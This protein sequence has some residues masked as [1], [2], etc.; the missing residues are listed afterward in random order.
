[1]WHGMQNRATPA[2]GRQNFSSQCFKNTRAT[3]FD[4]H[5]K[6]VPRDTVTAGGTFHDFLQ[7]S[8]WLAGLVSQW[9]FC[10]QVWQSPFL[11]ET[12][13]YTT[14]ACVVCLVGVGFRPFSCRFW[15]LFGLREQRFT[16]L[17]GISFYWTVLLLLWPRQINRFWLLVNNCRYGC[18]IFQSSYS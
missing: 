3:N 15:C 6:E 7:F 10:K 12:T 18:C 5:G 4:N 13:T 11:L 14:E 1:M 9:H 2:H 16:A 17:A 8:C